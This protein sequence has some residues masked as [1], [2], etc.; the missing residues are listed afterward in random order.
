MQI[1]II[2]W[3]LVGFLSIIL[4]Y[5]YDLRGEEFDPD[6]FT[7]EDIEISLLLFFLGYISLAI[8]L[9]IF[10]YEEKLF[11]KFIYKI[12]NIGVK[13]TEEKKDEEIK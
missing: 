13:K 11:A 12:V 1:F 2:S 3:F 7:N 9:G 6:Y 10:I 8:A 5:G 4:C